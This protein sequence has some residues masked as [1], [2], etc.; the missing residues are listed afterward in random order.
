[1]PSYI[2]S[3]PESSSSASSKRSAEIDVNG[4]AGQ[5]V[6]LK[7]NGHLGLARS[8]NT[9]AEAVIAGILKTPATSGFIADYDYEI[10]DLPTWTAAAGTAT[11]T[12]GMWYYLS[13][14]SGM[15]TSAAPN[16]GYLSVVGYALST[17]EF[18]FCP[19]YPI[20]L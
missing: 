14:T 11:L 10:V 12:P 20:K 15:M 4:S 3:Y 1:M 18:R 6:Y 16:V 13:G 9:E 5:L 17:T 7:S 8:Q 19:A 2:L